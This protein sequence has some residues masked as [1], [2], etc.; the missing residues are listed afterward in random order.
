MLLQ[1]RWF[2]IQELRDAVLVGVPPE[3]LFRWLQY[4]RQYW[5]QKELNY[6]DLERKK[7][8]GARHLMGYIIM[9]LEK[10]GTVERSWKGPKGVASR[11]LDAWMC[12]ATQKGID[13][14]NGKQATE[15]GSE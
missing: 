13:R 10:W 5:T 8:A 3:F 14:W 9:E 1:R 6:N 2:S 11:E 4:K 7:L 15:K 12:R